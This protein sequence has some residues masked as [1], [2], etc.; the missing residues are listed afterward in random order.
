MKAGMGTRKD[1]KYPGKLQQ[2]KQ[3]KTSTPGV[4][5][6][7]RRG[8]ELEAQPPLQ[9]HQQ[10]IYCPPC[11]HRV[12]SFNNIW[13]PPKCYQQIHNNKPTLMS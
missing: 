3:M 10:R 9:N 11:G 8:A 4:H 7:G 1:A 12:M 5:L 6:I 2:K 13:E